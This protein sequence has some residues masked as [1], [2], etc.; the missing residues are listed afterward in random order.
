MSKL[1]YRH[2]LKVRACDSL[3][4]PAKAYTNF[5]NGIHHLRS[6]YVPL[7]VF[8]IVELAGIRVSFYLWQR[9]D[10]LGRAKST[11]SPSEFVPKRIDIFVKHRTSYLTTMQQ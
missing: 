8:H 3:F 9:K 4:F 6:Y 7:F 11:S 10:Q 5:W 2:L 1:I